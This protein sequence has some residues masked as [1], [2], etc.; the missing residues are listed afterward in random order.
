MDQC[1]KPDEKKKCMSTMP[2]AEAIGNLMYA[3]LCIRLDICFVVGMVSHYQ[4]NPRPAHWVAMK[5][6]FRY[7]QGTTNFAL[8][9]HK[10]DLR[11]KGYNDVD[12]AGDRD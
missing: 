8:C 1:P 9:F 5:R 4:S 7:V 6:I 11:L 12:W 10:G 2:Y 3:M